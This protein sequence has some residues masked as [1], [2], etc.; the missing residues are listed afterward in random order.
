MPDMLLL[1]KNWWKQTALLLL[2]SLLITAFLVFTQRPMYLSVITAVPASAYTND[3]ARLFSENI[4]QLYSALGNPDDLELILGTARLDT[5]YRAV[6]RGFNLYDHYK[7]AETGEAAITKAAGLLKKNTS[8]IKSEYGELKIKVW[9]TDP[10]LAPRL[11]TAIFRQ[12]AYTQ[13]QLRSAV[14]RETLQALEAARSGSDSL[15]TGRTGIPAA[16]YDQLIAEY[17][18]QLATN[19]P[20]LIL[21]EE[22]RAATSP[23]KPKRLQ[24][25]LAAGFLSVLFSLALGLLLGKA[26]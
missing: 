14:N 12:L 13:Q 3:K 10:A 21:A 22:A 20:A 16:M 1:L 6:A 9:D 19:P 7:T 5:V 11:A 26:K 24:W 18:V 17:R 23:D 25:M 4:Q 8:V 2:L 15:T